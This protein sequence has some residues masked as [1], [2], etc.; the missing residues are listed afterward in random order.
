MLVANYSHYILL[1]R[2]F[3]QIKSNISISDD[4]SYDPSVSIAVI[5][6]LSFCFVII[7]QI[8][9]LI[10]DCMHKIFLQMHSKHAKHDNLSSPFSALRT[11]CSSLLLKFGMLLMFIWFLLYCTELKDKRLFVPFFGCFTSALCYA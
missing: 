11:V 1:H 3:F 10:F 6:D 5:T 7:S 4:P 9:D 8:D 2:R